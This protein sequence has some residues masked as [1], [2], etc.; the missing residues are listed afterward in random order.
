MN[1]NDSTRTGTILPEAPKK[2]L[3]EPYRPLADGAGLLQVQCTCGG[4]CG[5]SGSAHGH[6]GQHD[7]SPEQGHDHGHEHAHEHESDTPWKRLAAAGLFAA[8]SEG[9]HFAL[10]GGLFQEAVHPAGAAVVPALLETLPLIFALSAILLSGLET[11]RAGWRALSRFELNMM[12]L[13]SVAVTGAVLI[14]QYP[15]AAMVMVLFNISEAIEDRVLHRARRAI[16]E[17][18]ALSP[19][20][21][22]VRQADGSWHEEDIRR[23]PLGAVIRVR[24]GERVALDGVIRE[25]RS[26]VD[27]SPITGES[28]PVDKGPGDTVYAGTINT[29]GV[30]E[31][32]VTALASDTTLARIIH[33]VEQA[34]G[35]RAPIQRFVDSFARWY[36]PGI[37]AVSLLLAAVPPLFL[38]REWLTSIYTALVVLV[39]GCPCA[40][41]ISTPVTIVSGMAAATRRGV[42]V[43]GGLFLEMGRLLR[44]LALDKTGTLTH[45]R[46]RRVDAEFFAGADPLVVEAAAA[47]LAARS[48]H[49]VSVA[50]STY[51]AEQ[52]I[53]QAAVSDFLALPGKGVQG[54]CG[55]TL[56]Y[57]G[58][59]RLMRELGLDSEALGQSMRRHEKQ[60]RSVVALAEEGRVVA[61]FAVADTL[62]ESSVEAVH[63][64][65]ELGVRTVML[66]GDNED[67]AREIAA[68]AGVDEFRAGL[69][70]EEKLRAVEALLA[71]G[72]RVGMAGDGINDAP[73]LARADIGFAMARG[74]TD[75][76]METADVALMDDD[77][78]KIPRFIHLSR[79]VYGILVQNIVLA[80]G[81]K[82]LFFALT[83]FGFTSMW[84]AVFADVGTALMVVANG[85]RAAKK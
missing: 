52:G 84:M 14:G 12:A 85:L 50:L 22:A 29:S 31:F 11:Y 15:E 69:L 2:N 47:G 76:A 51:A 5:Q 55:S 78:R 57:M 7:H 79:A 56:W 62:R 6:A 82:A 3:L 23:I 43:K 68:Q 41:V 42:L 13:M 4:R 77:L 80:L 63:Q 65:R 59:R 21:A 17:L 49:P 44:V 46:P 8:L 36:T 58:N 48:D 45:G 71:D 10:E 40:L 60:G 54:R 28:L 26:A 53:G 35:R 25:G 81:V 16:R 37:F 20:K 70:P 72:L 18:L 64:L 39:I 67:A 9:F 73:A 34:Q 1:K 74:G 83:L 38:D 75:T 32:E 33:A 27:Q 19:E 61:I 66:T 24:P 30:F